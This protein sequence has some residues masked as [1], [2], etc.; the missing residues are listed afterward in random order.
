MR[1]GFRILHV[2]EVVRIVHKIVLVLHRGVNGPVFLFLV[3]RVVEFPVGGAVIFRIVRRG[4]QLVG[5]AVLP[6]PVFVVVLEDGGDIGKIRFRRVFLRFGVVGQFIRFGFEVVVVVGDAALAVAF[7]VERFDRRRSRFGRSGRARLRV[8]LA[9]SVG[10]WRMDRIRRRIVG[11]MPGGRLSV[12]ICVG[13]RRRV[14]PFA[15]RSLNPLMGAI[16]TSDG[17]AGGTQGAGVN[18][19]TCR[20]VLGK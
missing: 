15:R 14:K 17:L 13:Q 5:V 20:T 19:I 12:G 1:D 2:V 6:D 3:E 4:R 16:G 9:M 18:R 10:P 11:R 8:W 7:R